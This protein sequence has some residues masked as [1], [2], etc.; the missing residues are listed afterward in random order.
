MGNRITSIVR[1]LYRFGPSLTTGVVEVGFTT[2]RT[3][4]TDRRQPCEQR[5]S[6]DC[7][8]NM[9]ASAWLSTFT[10]GDID[11]GLHVCD[12]YP[13]GARTRGTTISTLLRRY[14]IVCVLCGA[15]AMSSAI[16]MSHILMEANAA[17]VET[18]VKALREV[19][20][21]PTVST[22]P[23]FLGRSDSPGDPTIDEW[24]SSFDL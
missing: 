2:Q 24:L 15:S 16:K 17:L 14:F 18:L 9:S 19:G 12:S 5:S 21:A 10:A 8:G 4:M 11:V 22:L 1:L 13:G 23:R 6:C 7:E 20:H 3:I